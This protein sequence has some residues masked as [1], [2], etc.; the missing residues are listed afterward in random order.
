[1][2]GV[3]RSRQGVDAAGLVHVVRYARVSARLRRIAGIESACVSVCI[4]TIERR[5]VVAGIVVC[6]GCM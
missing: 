3:G 4:D 1:M 5:D 2:R 6:I